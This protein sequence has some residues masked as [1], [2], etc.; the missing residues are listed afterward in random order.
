MP[1]TLEENSKYIAFVQE[2]IEALNGTK[3]ESNQIVW[4][5][6]SGDALINIVQSGSLY[7]TQVSCLND[8]TEVRYA[9]NLLRET[10]I[11]VQ[12]ESHP[13]EEAALLERLIN[14]SDPKFVASSPSDFFV[15]CFSSEKDDLSQW[16]AYGGG[17]MGM[18]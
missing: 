9:E 1:I 17:R 5:Y 3:I 16:R 11:E 12:K 14:N 10:F 6:T 2:Q 18:R 7:S 8:S 4:H 15:T 13:E